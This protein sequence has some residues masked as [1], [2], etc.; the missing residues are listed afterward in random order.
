L[1]KNAHGS[2]INPVESTNY[3]KVGIAEKHRGEKYR[4]EKI[5]TEN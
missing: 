4:A 1:E 3:N 2:C 5:L